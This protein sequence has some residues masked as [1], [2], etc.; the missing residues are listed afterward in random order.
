[1]SKRCPT[2]YLNSTS[3]K[4]PKYAPNTGSNLDA[5]DLGIKHRGPSTHR[6]KPATKR[7]GP[8]RQATTWKVLFG[9]KE[10][11]FQKAVSWMI[12]FT[13]VLKIGKVNSSDGRQ[14]E[15]PGVSLVAQR[16]SSHVPLQRPRVCRLGSRVWTWHRLE[17]HAV[18]GVPRIK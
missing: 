13:A 1:M 18:A 12:L 4:T 7:D 9:V 17:H 16:L 14:K 3:I 10:V 15:S 2:V 11:R 5:Q 8:S 6:N